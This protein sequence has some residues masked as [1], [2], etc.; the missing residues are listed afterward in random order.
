MGFR[1]IAYAA[2][3]AHF[4]FLAWVVLGGFVA[5]RWPRALVAHLLAIA[6]AALSV[7][8]TLPCPLTGLQN[9]AREHA[10]QPQLAHGFIDT[11][12]R[13]TLYPADH[14]RASQLLIA[15]IVAA[16]WALLFRWHQAARARRNRMAAPLA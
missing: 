5:W 11:Y 16:S 14:E 8:S 1:V 15:M 9:W 13:G 12:V 2:L 6:W 3:V 4:A 7:S 10:G